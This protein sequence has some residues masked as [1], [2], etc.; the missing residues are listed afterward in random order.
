MFTLAPP[1]INSTTS[2]E[3]FDEKGKPETLTWG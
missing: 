3:T 1:A 2:C